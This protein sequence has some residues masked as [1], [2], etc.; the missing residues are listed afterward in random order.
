VLDLKMRVNA[1]V[2][3]YQPDLEFTYVFNF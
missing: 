3:R 2:N 1:L